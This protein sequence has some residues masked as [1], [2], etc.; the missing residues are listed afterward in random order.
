MKRTASPN[1]WRPL[2]VTVFRN[3]LVAD[4]HFRRRRFHAERRCCM[5]DGLTWRRADLFCAG[6]DCRFLAIFSTGPSCG[7][8]W[9]YR[10]PT[11]ADSLICW[12]CCRPTTTPHSHTRLYT[13]EV[14]ARSHKQL[15]SALRPNLRVSF[16]LT[17]ENEGGLSCS[18]R[19]C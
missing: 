12:A 6:A 4:S 3:L 5:A 18:A 9:R 7:L 16:G 17:R 19:S 1:L 2:R 11:K 13:A 15:D 14:A 8:R 10:R